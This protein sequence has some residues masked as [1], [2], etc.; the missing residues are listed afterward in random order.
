MP[1]RFGEPS[2]EKVPP[3]LYQCPTSE[4]HACAYPRFDC[5]CWASSQRRSYHQLDHLQSPSLFIEPVGTAT[6]LRRTTK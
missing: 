5:V 2:R 4:L 3:I 1:H 6:A